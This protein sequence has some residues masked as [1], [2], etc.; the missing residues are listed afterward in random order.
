MKIYRTAVTYK[1]PETI[2]GTWTVT[3][4]GNTYHNLKCI[5]WGTE[6][7]TAIFKD[8]EGKTYCFS[9]P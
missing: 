3:S 4:C 1:D 5:Y 6:D 7:D 9:E 2:G 8:A